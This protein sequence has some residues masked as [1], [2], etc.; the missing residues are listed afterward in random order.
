MMTPDEL[1][2]HT[3]LVR[4]LT[5]LGVRDGLY[6]RARRGEVTR[7]H[8]GCFVDSAYWGAL[9]LADRHRAMAHLAALSF[10]NDL[11]F[12]HLTAAAMWRLPVLG[13]WPERVHVAGKPGYGSHSSATL[14]RH[15][16]GID[17]AAHTIDGLQVTSLALTVAQVAADQG[18]ACGVVVAD[19]AMRRSI[20][21]FPGL[22]SAVTRADLVTAASSIAL[23]H[24]GR[25]AQS[26]AEFADGS[27]DRPGESM[28]RVSMRAAGITPPQLQVVVYGASGARYVV[29]FYWPAL[30]QIGEFDGQLK[31][32]DPEFLRG[33]TPEQA[34]AD[35]KARED[36]LRAAGYK[37][38]RWGWAV[39][40]SPARL[41]AHLRLAGVR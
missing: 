40:L 22:D 29:D 12:C 11:V 7:V 10:G 16:Q 1:L 8:R 35:E 20:H 25:R 26:V 32:R 38:C 34:L 3:F 30:K 37:V 21:P 4:H 13:A 41:A 6:Q 27:A 9:P 33:R 19:A 18:F 28:S 31:Y 24:G 17:P 36:D 14:A 15:A 23:N 39:A 2:S 5:N